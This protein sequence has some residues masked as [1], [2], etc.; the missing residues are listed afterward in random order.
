MMEI[1][2]IGVG[3]RFGLEWIF[4]KIDFQFLSGHSYALTGHNG[5]GKSTLLKILSG[6]STP[7]EGAVKFI[8]NG[9]ELSQLEVAEKVS[10]AAPYI[11]LIEDFTLK[12]M[13][14]FHLRFKK[15]KISSIE[16]LMDVIEL[17]PHQD[18]VINKF[19]SGMMQRLK[20][21][22]AILTDS[23]ILL[24]DEPTSYLDENAIQWYRN[25]LNKYLD[26]RILII[27]S[28][29]SSEYSFVNGGILNVPD[30]KYH[31]KAKNG[32]QS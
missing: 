26:Q 3:K 32:T 8:L 24:L 28:N 13:L 4:R 17:K 29:Q 1:Q 22:L 14:E 23:Q 7:S 18:K 20:L 16:E 5:S 30:F 27:G 9:K 15:M 25:L 21:A 31:K 10:Y 19:S 12:E 2:L 11:Q 6:G